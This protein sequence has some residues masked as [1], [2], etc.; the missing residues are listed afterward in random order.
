MSKSMED[1]VT[2]R[3]PL[4][5]QKVSFQSSVDVERILFVDRHRKSIIKT[6]LIMILSLAGIVGLIVL[7]ASLKRWHIGLIWSIAL[8]L[9]FGLAVVWL[10]FLAGNC[11]SSLAFEK[12]RYKQML[13]WFDDLIRQANAAE[14]ELKLKDLDYE[15]Y[16]ERPWFCR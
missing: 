7:V 8:G 5:I 10:F 6:W 15:L 2:D 3:I 9:V 1:N 14:D 13:L 11:L 16:H 4:A 12:Y